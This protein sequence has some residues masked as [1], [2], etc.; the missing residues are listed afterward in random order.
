MLE[1]DDS[2]AF[3]MAAAKAFDEGEAFNNSMG[4]LRVPPGKG[5]LY[6][7]GGVRRNINPD[8]EPYI[9]KTK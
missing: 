2:V 1:L 8:S 5:F 4:E 6:P 7:V 3:A 9:Y